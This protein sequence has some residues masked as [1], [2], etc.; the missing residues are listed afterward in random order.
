MKHKPI[1]IFLL[2]CLV[3]PIPATYV[4]FQFQKR[5]IKKEIKEKIITTIHKEQLV[6]LKFT[7]EEAQKELKWEHSKEFEYKGN[8][9]DV[10]S[11]EIKDHIIYYYC[12]PDDDESELNKKIDEV[13]AYASG[14]DSQK[15]ENRE[16]LINFF[17]SL[18]HTKPLTWSFFKYSIHEIIVYKRIS[19]TNISL[20]TSLP[21]PKVI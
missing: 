13:L 8:M 10:V 11:V 7:K 1:S 18:F 14:K 2:F 16:R 17:K 4:Y 5:Q 9:Y 19:Y 12:W 15:K 3:L 20:L 21:P 6:T